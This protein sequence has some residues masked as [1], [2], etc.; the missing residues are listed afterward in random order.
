M[1][2]LPTHMKQQTNECH[3]VYVS[4]RKEGRNLS[5]ERQ[6][7]NTPVVLKYYKNSYTSCGY[8][9]VDN[10]TGKVQCCVHNN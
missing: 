10:T 9:T 8:L 6:A 2:L 7:D 4:P 1:D 3:L 5:E